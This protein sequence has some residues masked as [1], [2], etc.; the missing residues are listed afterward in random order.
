MTWFEILTMF[1]VRLAATL[2]F[3]LIVAFLVEWL[4]NLIFPGLFGLPCITYWQTVGLFVIIKLLTGNIK[5]EYNK[6]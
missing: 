1:A 5:I 4:W 2:V 6:K 3:G